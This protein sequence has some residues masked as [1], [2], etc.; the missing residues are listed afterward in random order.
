MASVTL[1]DSQRR[2]KERKQRYYW[3]SQRK[4]G[5]QWRKAKGVRGMFK[6]NR[7]VE[8][9]RRPKQTMAFLVRKILV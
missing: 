8:R 2:L 4:A 9:P 5:R 7:R 3:Q 6:R 1:R